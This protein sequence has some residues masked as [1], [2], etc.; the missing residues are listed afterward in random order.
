MDLA[1][2]VAGILILLG[3]AW[4]LSEDRW[5]VRWRLVGAGLALQVVLAALLLGVPFLRDAV[6]VLNDALGALERATTVGTSFLFGYLGGGPAPFAEVQPQYSFV[7]AFRAL[8]LILVVSALSAL[9]FHWRVI[10]ML[11]KA[12]AFVLEKSMGL[13]GAV[14]LSSAANVFVGMVEAPL[15]VKPYLLKLTRSELF[16]VMACGMA[17]IA[18]TVMALY[19]AMIAKA[20]PG[21]IGHLLIA[22]LVATPAAIL[23]AAVMVPGDTTSG[24]A[25]IERMDA[26]SMDAVTRGTVEGIALLIHVVAMLIVM[27]ALIALANL[28]MGLLPAFDGA[29]LTL[30]RVAGWFFAPLAW[31]TGVSWQDA[32]AAGQLLGTKTILNEF[33][34]YIELANLPP[35]AMSARSRLL[36]TYALCGFAN[37][38]SLGIMIGGMGAMVPERRAEIVGLGLKAI[39][40]GTLATCMAAAVVGMFV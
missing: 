32:H 38:G 28:L 34:A 17:T 39:V 27:V 9:L 20:V 3:L 33:V 1:H 4:A 11:V 35:E 14:G 15:I 37:F 30:Q 2:A 12:F 21:A 40:A 5:K 6:F 13:G 10:P 31:T 26:T 25:K 8:P 36:M 24:E 23:I 7:L 22:S 19:A 16:M 18:G 29:P